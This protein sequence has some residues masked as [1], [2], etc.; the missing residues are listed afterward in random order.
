MSSINHFSAR[1]DFEI[2]LDIV[3]SHTR[4]LDLGCG[5]GLLLKTLREEKH[6]QG[7]GVEL[8]QDKIIK[9]VGNN[10]PVIHEDLNNG[11]SAFKDK[12]FDYVILSQTLQAV[13]RPD[14]LV[15]EILRV[16]KYGVISFIN[17]GFLHS[18]LQ[19]MFGGRMPE[20]EELPFPWYN[21]PNIHLATIRDFRDL[22]RSKSARIVSENP[23][24]K[25]NMASWFPNIFA[26]TCVFVIAD[27]EK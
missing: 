9:S 20:T 8:S 13:E 10:V 6:V 14:I 2:I 16:G 1:K 24:E 11:L 4:V 18:R 25:G 12:S 15:S 22:C 19:I 7:V 23:I 26:S 5:D 21:S 27:I 17:M 3:P